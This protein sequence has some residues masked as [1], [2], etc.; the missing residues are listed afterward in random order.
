MYCHNNNNMSKRSKTA[1]NIAA[2]DV[3]SDLDSI[4]SPYR[5]NTPANIQWQACPALASLLTVCEIWKGGEGMEGGREWASDG[6]ER[7]GETH[8]YLSQ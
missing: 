1:P 3:K 5:F 4:R 8:S 6:G 2:V 7:E